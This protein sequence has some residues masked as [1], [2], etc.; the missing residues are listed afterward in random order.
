MGL[1]PGSIPKTALRIEYLKT[2]EDLRVITLLQVGKVHCLPLSFYSDFFIKTNATPAQNYINVRV[3][4]YEHI[5]PIL[6]W[7]HWLPVSLRIEY[8]TPSSLISAYMEMLPPTSRNCSPRKP[9]RG[10]YVQWRQTSS[11]HQG[12]NWRP[13]ETEPS[14]PLLP[15]CGMPSQTS[16][17]HHRLWMLLKKGLKAHLFRIA[18]N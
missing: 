15:D 9:P 6:K 11:S 2:T 5:T 16:W 3:R 10:T 12:Q 8:K 17:G 18:F 7:L 13:W 1:S 14:A 4:K